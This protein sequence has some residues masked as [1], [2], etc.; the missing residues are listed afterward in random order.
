MVFAPPDKKL[1]WPFEK[2]THIPNVGFT[3]VGKPPLLLIMKNKLRNPF[4]ALVGV[5]FLAV[6]SAQAQPHFDFD[7]SNNPRAASAA[8]DLASAAAWAA[9]SNPGVIPAFGPTPTLGFSTKAAPIPSRSAEQSVQGVFP[10][11]ASTIT[12]SV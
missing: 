3:P 1:G 8:R 11:I 2:R 10:P 9:N 5:T 6:S 12:P 4:L 7:A